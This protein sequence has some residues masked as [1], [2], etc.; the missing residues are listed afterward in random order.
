MT[1]TIL[2]HE[3]PH[4]LNRA[5]A[6]VKLLSLDCF[7]TLLWRDRHAPTDVFSELQGVLPGQRIVGEA[8]ARKIRRTLRRSNEVGL[9]E[10]YEQV[11]PNASTDAR[12]QAIAEELAAEARSCFAFE[13]TVELMR[14]AKAEGLAVIIV[15]DTYLDVTQLE[16][17]IRAAAGDEVAD[18]IDRVFASSQAGISKGEG[19][20]A[21]AL[22][23][24]KCRP[25][26]ALHL[27]D[28]KAADFEASRAL[29]VPALHLKQF[30]TAALQRLRFERA[31]GQ[32]IGETSDGVRG[33]QTHRAL[34][35][36]DETSD[37][38]PVKGLG[39]SVLGPVFAAFDQWLH[40]QAKAL[41]NSNGGKVHWLFMLRDGHL[42]W[43]VHEAGN[44][45]GETARVE[46]SRFAAT[47]ASLTTRDAYEHHLAMEH[48]LNPST[49]ARQMLL[50]EDEIA[51]IIGSPESDEEKTEA[52]AKLLTEL[53]KGQRQKTTIRRARAFADRLTSHVRQAANP[54][55]GDTLMLV[56]LGYN[57]SAQNCVDALLRETFDVHVAGRYLLLREMQTTGLDKSGL[58]DARNF[59]P[60]FL[61]AL[62]GNVAVIEQL[63]TCELGSVVDYTQ[64]GDPIRKDSAVKGKQSEVRD[65]VQRG[66]VSFAKASAN[67]PVIRQQDSHAE[68][69]WRDG[70]AAALGRFMF[71]PLPHELDVV[72]RFEHDVNMGSERMVAL[73]DADHAREGMRR[74]G[75]FYMKGSAR[76]FLPAEL[77]HED[78]STRLALIAQKRF[79]LGLNYTDYA[80][81]VQK[82][83][84]FYVNEN[85]TAVSSVEARATH[86]G[87]FSA[88]V[89]LGER[90]YGA[91]L[92]LG[93]A[94]EWIELASITCAPVSALTGST[95]NDAKPVPVTS[96]FDGLEERAP[97]LFECTS[98]HA[99]ALVPPDG[100][101]ASDEPLMLEFVFR[102]L[103]KRGESA[104][105]F[106]ARAASISAKEKAA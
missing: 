86:D 48:G 66:V 50:N 103:R 29:G 52:S 12:R 95:A 53:R 64:T 83:P 101:P 9:G 67:P 22:K 46:I 106:A 26:E 73:F 13:P 81:T 8:N 92:Q 41:A 88:R 4:A 19:L 2:P 47:A 38:D 44:P 11:M 72:S 58:I 57:G 80:P 23:T 37:R 60:E 30:G 28:N 99:V 31:F 84:V 74:R 36:R 68:R 93:A 56:D 45:V 49:L 21:K 90:G 5:P 71:L 27:G 98:E 100:V 76:M 51:R 94:Y 55:P 85:D 82:L 78:M 40:A 105:P 18:L 61:E 33:L 3:L 32:L 25:H 14:A 79:G 62:C 16:Q 34:I 35:S 39:Y 89:P 96:Q 63:A 6:G 42:P 59:D 87:Y 10:I 104:I 102:P 24:M 75:L 65:A 1:E 15:S 91:A 43:L 7:D 17:L 97:G 69:A 77:A 70:A 54:Q 20:L